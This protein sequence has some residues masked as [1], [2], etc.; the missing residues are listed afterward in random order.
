[1]PV[2]LW[3]INIPKI[4]EMRREIFQGGNI[5]SLKSLEIMCNYLLQK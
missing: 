2:V 4:D 3:G 1:M 5:P